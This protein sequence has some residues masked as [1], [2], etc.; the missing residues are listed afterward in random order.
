MAD[1]GLE[2]RDYRPGE[3][4]FQQGDVGDSAYMVETGKIEIAVGNQ[5][6]GEVVINVIEPGE[7]FGEMALIDS[8]PRMATARAMAKTRCIVL[9]KKVFESVLKDSHPVLNS[10]IRTLMNRLREGGRKTAKGLL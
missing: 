4:I 8:S 6:K 2:R 9:P 1:D 7:M 5:T 10:V 3:M